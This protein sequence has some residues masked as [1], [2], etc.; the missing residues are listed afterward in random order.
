MR[1]ADFCLPESEPSPI[2]DEALHRLSDGM[3]QQ[4]SRPT[5]SIAPALA[6]NPGRAR[7]QSINVSILLRFVADQAGVRQPLRLAY[8]GFSKRAV[9]IDEHGDTPDRWYGLDQKLEPLCQEFVVH[10]GNTRDVASGPAEA[11]DD[12]KLNGIARGAEHDRNSRGCGLCVD[13]RRH[14]CRCRDHRHAA[15]DQVSH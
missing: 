15:A 4:R 5:R 12:T 6:G 8:D 2:A 14:A 3:G 13:R 9:R 10:G 11:G 1:R 7:L